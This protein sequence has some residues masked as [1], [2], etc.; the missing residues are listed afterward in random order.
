LF[1]NW[2]SSTVVVVRIIAKRTLRLFWESNRRYADA[3]RALEDWHAQVSQAD[4]S[5]PAHVKNQYADASILKG[6]RVVFNIC[7]NRYRLIVKINYPYRVVYIR[8]VGTH[9]EYDEIDAETV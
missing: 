7:G 6:G 1:P 5:T 3:K 4:W 8:F 2:E 9:A